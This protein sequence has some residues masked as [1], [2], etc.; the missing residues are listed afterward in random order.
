MKRVRTVDILHDVGESLNPGVD[1]GPDR[2]CVRPGHGLAH[3]RESCVEARTGKLPHALREHLPDP[4]DRRR[5]RTAFN[6]ELLSNAAQPGVIHGSKAVG[7]AA[8]RCSPSACARRSAMRW[9]PSARRAERSRS[10]ARD[11]RGD[12]RGDQAPARP[13]VGRDRR[14]ARRRVASPVSTAVELFRRI[15]GS[16]RTSRSSGSSGSTNEL[17][18]P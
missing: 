6:V 18:L 16:D 5:S 12:P 13:L 10:L 3:R 8:A 15:R 2:R 4:L 9:Q 11:A 1:R 7:G 14:G 17:R